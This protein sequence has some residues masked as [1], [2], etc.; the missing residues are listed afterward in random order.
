MEQASDVPVAVWTWMLHTEPVLRVQDPKLHEDPRGVAAG[1]ELVEEAL[2]VAANRDRRLLLGE[3]LAPHAVSSWLPA[4]GLFQRV[5]VC[6]L[7]VL[8]DLQ[9]GGS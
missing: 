9:P 4:L 2:G 5:N 1:H 7:G 3:E 6:A 8:E